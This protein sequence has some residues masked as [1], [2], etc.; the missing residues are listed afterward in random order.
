MTILMKNITHFILIAAIVLLASCGSS[1]DYIS[2]S[3]SSTVPNSYK[4]V[5]LGVVAHYNDIVDRELFIEEDDSP[6]VIEMVQGIITD[7]VVGIDAAGCTTTGNP[8][9]IR[10][11]D[12]ALKYTPEQQE[13]LIAHELGHVLGFEHVADPDC[14][15]APK[16]KDLWSRCD[17]EDQVRREYR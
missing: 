13:R 1:K 8:W 4:A 6:N 2:F 3:I 15:M 5:V 10:I 17:F 14:I 12:A 16:L 7:C 9:L 11:S